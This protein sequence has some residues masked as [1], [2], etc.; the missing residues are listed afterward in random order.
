MSKHKNLAAMNKPGREDLSRYVRRTMRQ[1]RL[2]VRDVELQSGGQISNG[3]VS[4]IMSGSVTNLS[5]DKVKALAR[6]LGVDVHE[7]LDVVCG[8]RERAASQLDSPRWLEFLDLMRRIVVSPE[9]LDIL[10][11]A[12][13]LSSEERL[14][15]LKYVRKLNESKNRSQVKSK[16]V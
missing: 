13:L 3:Y 6:G 10:E 11:E 9:M 2:K 5:I 14:I 15:V 8:P 16:H 1:K 12:V 4:G 7:V